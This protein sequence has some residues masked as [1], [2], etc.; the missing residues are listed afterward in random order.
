MHRRDDVARF[1]CHVHRIGLESS[2]RPR[3]DL[4]ASRQRSLLVNQDEGTS[5]ERAQPT[6]AGRRRREGLKA[7][8]HTERAGYRDEFVG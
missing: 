7:D 3:E 5:A 8:L 6:A 2:Q 1:R 4:Y